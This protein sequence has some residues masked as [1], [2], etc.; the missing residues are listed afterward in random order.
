MEYGFIANLLLLML[1]CPLSDCKTLY[2]RLR[3]CTGLLTNVIHNA[4]LHLT[5]KLDWQAILFFAEGVVYLA[6]PDSE[7]IDRAELQA[8]VWEEVSGRLASKMLT[9]EIGF[10]RDGKGLKVAPQTLEFLPSAQLIQN[11]P[12]VVGVTIR[13]ETDPATPKRL[14]R[15]DVSPAEMEF[16][17]SGADLRSDRI[18]EFIVL[19]MFTCLIRSSSSLSLC[20]NSLD[21]CYTSPATPI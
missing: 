3:N 1:Y 20:P 9:G 8:A 16:L 11:L 12:N 13:N 7:S 6:P 4:L 15:L 5:E 14:A 10:K 2:H 18:A 21:R 17:L 19:P